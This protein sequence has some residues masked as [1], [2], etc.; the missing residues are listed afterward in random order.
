MS[1]DSERQNGSPPASAHADCPLSHAEQTRNLLI[2]GINVTLVYLGAP[3][4]YVGLTQASLCDKLGASKTVSNLPSTLYFWMTPLPIVVAWYFCAVRHLKPVLVV[5]YVVE[6]PDRTGPFGAKEVGQ[7]PLLPM[8][9]A[10]ANAVFDAV[11]VRIDEIPVSFEKVFEALQNKREGKDARHGPAL[12]A[13]PAVDFGESL[14]VRTPWQGG[15]GTA[16][17]E[18]KREKK[19]AR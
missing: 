6:D 11:G 14:K 4:L 18:P 8:M 17:N 12:D 7:G 16:W 2:Y 10:V 13:V 3:V 15:D 1:A 19:A 9:P 5:T